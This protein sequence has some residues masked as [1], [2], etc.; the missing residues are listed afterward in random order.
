MADQK[1]PEQQLTAAPPTIQAAPAAVTAQLPASSTPQI[2][3]NVPAGGAKEGPADILNGFAAVLWPLLIAFAIFIFRDQ[4]ASLVRRLRKGKAF[5]AEAE[6]DKE[7][8][9]LNVEVNKAKEETGANVEADAH[10]QSSG[11]IVAEPEARLERPS[12]DDIRTNVLAEAARSPRLGL[13]LLSAEIDRL[14]GR[15]A[16]ATGQHERRTLRE[17]LDLWRRQLPPH[18]SAAYRL[19]SHVR[20]RIVHGSDASEAEI[21]RA[22]DSGLALYEALA[23]IPIEKNVVAHPGVD[24]FG[25]AACTQPLEGKGL[26]METTH[27]GNKTFRIYPTTMTHFQPG[28]RLTWEWNMNRVWGEAWYRDPDTGEI[29]HAWNSSAEFIGRD[30]DQL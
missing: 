6:F 16:A 14:A 26:I 19:F 12:S 7:L 30:L 22:I 2:I 15:I 18:T 4:I 13:M 27:Q 17:Q 24:I 10:D 1:V 25:D 29:K 28:M 23:S 9:A 5:G 11:A 21:L 20:N 3:I 8:A